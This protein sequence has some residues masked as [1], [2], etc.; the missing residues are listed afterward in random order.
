MISIVYIGCIIFLFVTR[1]VQKKYIQ[2]RNEILKKS[3]YKK[4][5]EVDTDKL[6]KNYKALEHFMNQINDKV[7]K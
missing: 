5:F 2:K 3:I 6:N 1:I 4:P 7:N